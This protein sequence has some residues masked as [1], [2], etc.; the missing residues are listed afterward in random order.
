MDNANTCKI[1]ALFDKKTFI[2]ASYDPNNKGVRERFQ[3]SGYISDTEDY[4]FI[5]KQC[6]IDFLKGDTNLLNEFAKQEG[7]ENICGRL[8]I[9]KDVA[10]EKYEFEGKMY[11]IP[12]LEFTIFLED[13]DF[14]AIEKICE[15]SISNCQMLFGS[16]DFS[17][18]EFQAKKEHHFRIENLNVSETKVYAIVGF[19]L[20]SSQYKH[21]ILPKNERIVRSPEKSLRAE[22]TS[23][24]ISISK[25]SF[26]VEFPGGKYNRI[27]C[28]GIV[29]SM[30]YNSNKELDGLHC[31]IEFHEYET[32]FDKEEYPKE[33]YAGNF[34]LHSGKHPKDPFISIQLRFKKE[35]FGKFLKHI[36]V[37]PVENKIF[38][39]CRITTLNDSLRLGSD[40]QADITDFTISNYKSFS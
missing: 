11:E 6:F 25:I 35:E 17:C 9:Q 7:L 5:H 30:P 32:D 20:H 14:Y 40:V 39:K 24:T 37:A 3:I 15:N 28:D 1:Y 22:G 13:Q 16:F 2:S 31:L 26:D 23:I 21:K 12:P 33:A 34:R 8:H 36:F 38:V 18:I 19:S 27:L 10:P 4:R 29:H